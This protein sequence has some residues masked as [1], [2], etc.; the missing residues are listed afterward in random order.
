MED[1][2]AGV[3]AGFQGEPGAF[4]E[5]AARALLGEIET[6][7]YRTFADVLEALEARRIAYAV[8]PFENSLHGAIAQVHELITARP[9]VQIAGETQIRIEQCLIGV[10][11]ATAASIERVA[12]HPVALAQCRRFLSA[13]PRWHILKSDDTA[14]AVRELMQRADPTGAAIGPE[15]AAQR[16]GALVLQRAVQ[17][18]PENVT[19]FW[20]VTLR[21]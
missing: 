12:S 9:H 8:L 11:E 1:E 19:R 15:A 10:P 21:E 5:Q 14:G 16:Y 4:S 7:G 20:L 6:S 17:D 13:H 18:D 3:V 2:H